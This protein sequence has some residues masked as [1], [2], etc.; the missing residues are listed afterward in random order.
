M[1][2]M[3]DGRTAMKKCGWLA[4]SGLAWACA[5]GAWGQWV[6]QEIPLK[7]GWNAV[8]VGVEPAS[9]SLEAL[10]GEGVE[11]V[12]RWDKRFTTAEYVVDE[13][14][15][16]LKDPHW[17]AWY[18]GEEIGFLSTLGEMS[19]WRCYLVKVKEGSGERV[20]TIKGKA[21]L[22][23]VEWYPNALNL[24]GFPVGENGATF[25][26]WF[27]ADKAVDLSKGYD[28]GAW[29]IASDGSERVVS[30]PGLQKLAAGEAVWVHCNGAS[31]YAGPLAVTTDAG[32]GLD[33]GAALQK[34]GVAV[35]NL[36]GTRA[37]TVT[38][39]LRNSEA[40][41]E[42]EEQVAG[43]VPLYLAEGGGWTAFSEKTVEL[44]P[45]ETWRG[46][47]GVH[48]ADM[49]AQEG[50][51][52]YQSVLG[53]RDAE[54]KIAIDVPVRAVRKSGVVGAANGSIHEVA[55]SKGH[56]QAGLWLGEAV[57]TEVNCP[58]YRDEELLPVRHSARLK[59]IVHV[60]ADGTA[61][62]LKEAWVAAATNGSGTAVYASMDLVPPGT[63][64]VWRAS[65]VT[66]PSM[67]PLTLG[68]NGF[69]TNGISGTVKL[70]YDDPT[71]PF[72]H[73]Y[74]PLFDNKNGQFEP[75]D[76]PVESRDVTRKIELVPEAA[77]AAAL[78]D[79][80]TSVG[81]TYRETLT[82]LRA[83]KIVASGRFRLEKAVDGA[84]LVEKK[85]GGGGE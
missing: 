6:T 38:L 20:V 78:E 51:S 31:D 8:C 67:A 42:G 80:D 55:A 73:R 15:P 54:G 18:P 35:E 29:Q 61:K 39:A 25:A 45:G 56:G 19:G 41:P 30:K 83:Q 76:G 2:R 58:N 50:N 64:D 9:G 53:V 4:V 28:N 23:R 24:V 40:A 72:L 57:L 43:G 81:G 10:A 3:I 1:G 60:G 11:G 79:P 13:G 84:A 71:N 44:G 85:K 48:R 17:K 27:E 63:G 65:A 22:P 74:H 5:G 32:A 21:K 26:E 34:I 14:S 70:A 59:L 7:E 46:T 36:S 49:E 37:R 82:G 52:A 33:F 62:L 16:L 12:W 77:D 66:L 68:T 47:F 69:A 75:Y